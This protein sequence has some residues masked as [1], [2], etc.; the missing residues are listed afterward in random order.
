MKTKSHEKNK[1][2]NILVPF[3]HFLSGNAFYA[4]SVLPKK[5]K[6]K[7]RDLSP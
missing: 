4:E 1:D 7:N 3:C 5:T 6:S 2:S